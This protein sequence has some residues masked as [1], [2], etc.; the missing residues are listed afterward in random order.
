MHP[1]GIKPAA[2]V[3][4]DSGGDERASSYSVAQAY[5]EFL[6][7]PHDMHVASIGSGHTRG[8]HY[9]AERRELIV[10]IH[11]DLV[12]YALGSKAWNDNSLPDV[13]WRG[14]RH[15]RNP[16]P[17]RNDGARPLWLIAATDGPYN[18]AFPDVHRR[19]ITRP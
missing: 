16:A 3:L 6:G 12:V 2:L 9:H 4:Q 7:E 18:C 13:Q 17:V 1:I 14:C 11:Q 19:V 10:V 8:N 5:L 15:S